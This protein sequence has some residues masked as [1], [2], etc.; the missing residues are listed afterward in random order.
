[1]DGK[2]K[3]KSKKTEAETPETTAKTGNL[4][5]HKGGDAHAAN[6]NPGSGGLLTALQNVADKAAAYSPAVKPNT[7]QPSGGGVVWSED[8]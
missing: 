7:R 2:S 1:L 4:P 6:P 3:L 5:Q 8:D